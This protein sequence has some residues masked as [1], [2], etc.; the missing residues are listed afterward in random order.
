M[1]TR[2]IEEKEL[3]IGFKAITFGTYGA[4]GKATHGLIAAAT[5][6][7]PARLPLVWFYPRSRK[8]AHANKCS[9]QAQ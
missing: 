1:L 3:N 5:A 7:T 6:N 2:I 8:R 4:F 9:I